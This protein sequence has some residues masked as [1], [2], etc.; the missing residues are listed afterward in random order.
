MNGKELKNFPGRRL[1]VDFDV[2]QHAKSSYKT[3]MEDE[4]NTRFNKQI[5]KDMSKKFNRKDNEKK[6]VETFGK[7]KY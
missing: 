5:K 2:K 4:G 6:K 7:K 1:K 3:N